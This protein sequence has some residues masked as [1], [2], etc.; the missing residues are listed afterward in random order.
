MGNP[1][2]LEKAIKHQNLKIN[3]FPL[4]QKQESTTYYKITPN[5]Q[6]FNLFSQTNFKK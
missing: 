1:Q 4:N 5:I 3:S 2:K 6:K